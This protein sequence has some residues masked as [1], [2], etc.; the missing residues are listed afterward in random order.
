MVEWAVDDLRRAAYFGARLW[1]QTPGPIKTVMV[2]AIGTLIGAQAIALPLSRAV[3][4]FE[5]TAHQ[6]E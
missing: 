5:E 4:L 2:A 6:A 1:D 3:F